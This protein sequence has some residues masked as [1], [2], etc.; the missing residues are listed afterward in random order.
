MTKWRT[1][2]G[3]QGVRRNQTLQMEGAADPVW[4]ELFRDQGRTWAAKT[5]VVPG[6]LGGEDAVVE[7]LFSLF[8]GD[9]LITE[10]II[11]GIKRGAKSVFHRRLPNIDQLRIDQRWCLICNQ[12]HLTTTRFT[13]SIGS[14]RF[15]LR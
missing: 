6:G 11:S 7:S 13:N 1:L 5:S 12:G 2:L 9:S 8:K 14:S 10:T 15:P 4:S 3:V